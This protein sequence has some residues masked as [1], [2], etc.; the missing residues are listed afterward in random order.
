MYKP[1]PI[2]HFSSLWT[3]SQ[4]NPSA[5]A[6]IERAMRMF[7]RQLPMSAKLP[8]ARK[9]TIWIE[10]DIPLQRST[11]LSVDRNLPAKKRPLASPAAW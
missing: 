1:T 5:Y 11:M 10:N 6:M 2:C 7:G 8:M 9:T 3:P 4:A